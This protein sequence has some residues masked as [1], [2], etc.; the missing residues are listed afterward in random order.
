MNTERQHMVAHHYGDG[1]ELIGPVAFWV[2]FSALAGLCVLA[3]ALGLAQ[4]VF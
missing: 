2:L 4:E 1:D 3:V